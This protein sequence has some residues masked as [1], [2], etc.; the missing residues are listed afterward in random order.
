MFREIFCRFRIPGLSKRFIY[1]N[2]D[3]LIGAP[4]YLDDFINENK[5]YHVYMSW[6]LP[7]CAPDCPWMYVSDG[8]CDQPCHNDECQ[9][10]G[11]D[12]DIEVPFFIKYFTN[13]D[14]VYKRRHVSLYMS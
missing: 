13:I 3:I 5:G 8:Q 9:M 7:M 6:P 1:F 2:D 11:G 14:I 12:C 4:L 10:D